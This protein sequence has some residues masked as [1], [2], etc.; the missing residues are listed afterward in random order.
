M[1][2]EQGFWSEKDL[3]LSL[4]VPT[5]KLSTHGHG[6]GRVS[7]LINNNANVNERSQSIAL[8]L[9]CVNCFAHI[10]AYNPH[11]SWHVI[12]ILILC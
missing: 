2:L 12:M 11:Y 8:C 4:G 10:R 1:E 3:D 7:I 6:F 9:H 5:F